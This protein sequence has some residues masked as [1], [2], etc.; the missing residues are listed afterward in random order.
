LWEYF[1]SAANALAAPDNELLLVEGITPGIAAQIRQKQRVDAEQEIA[2]AEKAGVKI[3]TCVDDGYPV[4]LKNISSYP[5]VMYVRGD[6]TADDLYNVALVGTRH[7]TAYGRSVAAMFARQF[8]E[9]GVTTVSGLARGID[10]EVHEATLAAGGRTIAVLGNGLNCHYPVENRKLED[11]IAA[12]GALVSEFPMDFQPDR[13]NFPRRNRIIAGLALATLVVEADLK[14]GALI[15]AGFALEQGKDVFAVPGPI[16]S[17]YSQGPHSLLRQG[18]H[19]A[20]SA[21]DV[22]DTIQ[23]LAEW[24]IRKSCAPG[25]RENIPLIDDSQHAVLDLLAQEPEGMSIDRVG[26]RANLS[27]GELARCM[28][29]MELKGLVR[30]L[31]GRVYIKSQ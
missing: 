3:L 22:I 11:R 13:G 12:C 4:E 26:T 17:K 31:P 21:A 28:L 6:I 1:G 25:P 16:F 14:S 20:E 8:A 9:K 15:T 23:P 24:R 5:P 30:S 29:D 7:P 18:A 19:I 10:T 27:A 2:R